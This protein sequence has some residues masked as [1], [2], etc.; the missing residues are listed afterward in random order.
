MVDASIDRAA[1]NDKFFSD[2]KY[3]RIHEALRDARLIVVTHEHD[4]HTAGVVRSPFLAD[5]QRHTMLTRAQMRTL[6]GMVHV[7]QPGGS[8]VARGADGHLV[9]AHVVE[10]LEE[11]G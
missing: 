5:V 2:E 11:A 3:R 6:R 9:G 7:V 1:A 8:V 4:D 10:V